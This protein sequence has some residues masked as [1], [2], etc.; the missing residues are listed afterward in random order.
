MK[1][2]AYL[3]SA[4][5]VLL[6]FFFGSFIINQNSVSAVS[7]RTEYFVSGPG[8]YSLSDLSGYN[9]LII[10][11]DFS[12]N[13]FQ[14]FDFT[15]YSDDTC[16]SPS[17][18]RLIGTRNSTDYIV[19]LSG[20]VPSSCL[21]LSS[22]SINSPTSSGYFTLS[23]SLPGVTTPSGSISISQNGTY[24]VTSYS[25]AVVNV[26][27]EVIYGDYHDDLVSINNTIMIGCAIPLVIYFFYC[28]Y[29]MLLKGRI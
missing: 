12:Q 8:F 22:V 26:E 25:E 5:F 14:Y 29:R 6:G 4:L 16:S 11:F 15:F 21:S 28:I 7:E 10:H 9:Y 23:E 20:L 18:R 24:D 19:S 1:W 27:N 3:C 17:N 13:Q 2:R